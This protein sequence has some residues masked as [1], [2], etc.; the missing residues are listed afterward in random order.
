[1]DTYDVD[2]GPGE[3]KF[4]YVYPFAFPKTGYRDASAVPEGTFKNQF[5]ETLAVELC[6]KHVDHKASSG[7]AD[8]Q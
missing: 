3:P 4:S 8:G 2:A 6:R 5:I 7:I 1:M